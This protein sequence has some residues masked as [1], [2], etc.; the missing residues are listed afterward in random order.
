MPLLWLTS[1]T[2][3]ALPQDAGILHCNIN[4]KA[5]KIICG[6]INSKDFV[7]KWIFILLKLIS[8]EIV[9]DLPVFFCQNLIE[10]A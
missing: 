2:I 4:Y 8:G 3:P 10:I 1:S 9:W 5:I 7:T 6:N